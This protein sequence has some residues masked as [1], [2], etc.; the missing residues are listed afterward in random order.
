MDLLLSGGHF[1]EGARWHDGH[2]W[3]SDLYA[4][5]V[6][7]ITPDGHA[8]VVVE[9]DDQPSGLGWLPDGTLLVVGM[10]SRS[11]WKCPAGEPPRLHADITALTGGFTND[12]IVDSHGR[13][14]VS[15]LGFDLFTGAPPATTTLVR[16]DPDG[17]SAIVADGLQFPNGL[18][19]SP[20]GKT[21]IVA[22]TFGGRLT[23]FTIEDDGSLSGQR[24]WAQIGREPSWETTHS[25][26]DTDFA[27]DG[28]AIDEEGCVWVADALN[29][30]VARVV[31]GGEIR[32]QIKAPDGLGLYS[33]ALGGP[34][35]KTL[36]LCTAPDFDDVKRKVAR[37]ARLYLIRIQE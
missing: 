18:V 27:P 17:H 14:F 34:D 24:C 20:D 5:Q 6:L 29:G 32:Q 21:L 28:C 31:E 19:I 33:C 12:M 26:L 16:V 8:Q 4:G 35:G 37:A 23:A 25:L 13:A 15:N 22:E 11:V 3:V 10:K 9:L 36:I 7:K 1:Y 30:R 2:F